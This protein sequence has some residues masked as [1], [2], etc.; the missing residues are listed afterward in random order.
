ME[1][2]TSELDAIRLGRGAEIVT[3]TKD[4]SGMSETEKLGVFCYY[5]ILPSSMSSTNRLHRKMD[6]IRN[7]SRTS[8]SI[9]K[10]SQFHSNRASPFF[11]PP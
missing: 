8:H 9:S 1:A 10:T 5:P 7:F 3:V 4:V 11:Y 6:V 2:V